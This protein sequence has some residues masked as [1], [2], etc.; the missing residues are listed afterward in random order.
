MKTHTL[1]GLAVLVLGW[2]THASAGDVNIP[3]PADEIERQLATEPF[4]ISSAE[5][6]RPKA[7]GDITLKAEVSFSGNPPY[8]VKLR[9]AEPGAEDFNN[10]PRYDL[11]AYELQKLFLDPP[12]YVVPPTALRFV[13]VGQLLPYAQEARPTFR[14]SDEV[15]V[16]LQYW[17]HEVKVIADVYDAERFATDAVY[18]RHI[19]QMN[20]LT[21]LI[22]HGDSNVGNF[23]ISRAE[24]GPRVFSIDNGVAF[25][26]N[27]SDRSD[28]WRKLRVDRLPADAIARLRAIDDRVLDDRL[29]VLAQW[30][31][32][33]GRWV[34]EPRGPNLGPSRGVRQKDGRVQL[35]LTNA[36]I[37]R[38]RRVLRRLLQDVE[39]GK[40]STF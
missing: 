40:V 28:L 38:V 27:E 16:V 21:A 22:E 5:I 29:G 36:E 19:G 12:E 34:A 8:R 26:F 10:R 14:G 25:A 11:A 7:K 20:I 9:R 1:A 2:A 17:L 4:T 24:E 31:L 18:A 39:D 35:G 37:A 33:G 13:P 15:L 30:H 23:L 3:L 32:E 6:S